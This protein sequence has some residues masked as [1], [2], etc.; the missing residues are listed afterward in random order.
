MPGSMGTPRSSDRESWLCNP[1]REGLTRVRMDSWVS[2]TS[3]NAAS[4]ANI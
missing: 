4:V 2:G 1:S 3:V